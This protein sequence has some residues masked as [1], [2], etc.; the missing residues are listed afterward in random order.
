MTWRLII[1]GTYGRINTNHPWG[2]STKR[3]I[4][5]NDIRVFFS[6][7]LKAGQSSERVIQKFRRSVHKLSVSKPCRGSWKRPEYYRN[8]L[9]M[10][11][12]FKFIL[13]QV[14]KTKL[15]NCL[16][17][18]SNRIRS[19]W[20]ARRI[21]AGPGGTNTAI[22]PIWNRYRA[23][24]RAE[25]N[26]GTSITKYSLSYFSCSC[27]FWMIYDPNTFRLTESRCLLNHHFVFEFISKCRF[28]RR[29]EGSESQLGISSPFFNGELEPVG[30]KLKI[31]ERETCCVCNGTKH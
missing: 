31:S 30:E 28:P 18:K 10:I 7:S 8:S 3:K 13:P 24:I 12:K 9:K 16:S 11:T 17:I 23:E 26:I 20:T 21:S 27:N 22:A 19:F 5:L 29:F 15:V 14:F 1:E 4:D 25:Q 2:S 6:Q